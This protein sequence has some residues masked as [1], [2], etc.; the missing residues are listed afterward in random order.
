V[1]D[2]PETDELARGNHVVPTKFAEDLEVSKGRWRKQFFW[3]EQERDKWRDVAEKLHS[4]V[5]YFS[6]Q[7]LSE[8]DGF[9]AEK[10]AVREFMR[11]KQESL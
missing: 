5:C 9:S 3:M 8:D 11:L 7:L 1:S 10:E 4:A 2:T 6:P